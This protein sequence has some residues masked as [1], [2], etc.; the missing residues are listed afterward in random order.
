MA[1]KLAGRS[2]KKGVRLGRG[3]DGIRLMK[4]EDTKVYVKC[5]EKVRERIG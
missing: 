5:M 3:L 2:K 1:L 4:S